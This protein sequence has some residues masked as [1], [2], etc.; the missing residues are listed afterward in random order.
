MMITSRPSRVLVDELSSWMLERENV[1]SQTLAERPESNA[2]RLTQ[3]RRIRKA[4]QHFTISISTSLLFTSG[5]GCKRR[6]QNKL[7]RNKVSYF[8]NSLWKFATFSCCSAF[9]SFSPEKATNSITMK[10][11]RRRKR[12]PRKTCRSKWDEENVIN[13]SF[14]IVWCFLPASWSLSLSLRLPTAES[15][16]SSVGRGRENFSYQLIILIVKQENKSLNSPNV[17]LSCYKLSRREIRFWR[18]GTLAGFVCFFRERQV[19]RARAV[20][21]SFS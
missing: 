12:K 17:F 6:T 5:S 20:S 7:P 8:I 11:M 13:L 14:L 21:I 18:S 10:G 15:R 9:G 19:T 4:F 1:N 16:L 2:K 3:F